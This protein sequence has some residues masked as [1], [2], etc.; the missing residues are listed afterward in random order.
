MGEREVR[1]RTGT[2]RMREAVYFARRPLGDTSDRPVWVGSQGELF[3]HFLGI[4]RNVASSRR[5]SRYASCILLYPGPHAFVN[6]LTSCRHGVTHDGG[7]H[8]VASAL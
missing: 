6:F 5:A 8:D 4:I 2:G 1:S 3:V 7:A